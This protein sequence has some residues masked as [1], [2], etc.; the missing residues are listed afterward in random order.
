MASEEK[1][2]LVARDNSLMYDVRERMRHVDEIPISGMSGL[3]SSSK[4]ATPTEDSADLRSNPTTGESAL[5]QDGERVLEPRL[6][7]KRE[8][9]ISYRGLVLSTFLA[10]V[11]VGMTVLLSVQ[12]KFLY[13]IADELNSSCVD[14]TD[15]LSAVTLATINGATAVL[16]ST[17]VESITSEGTTVLLREPLVS[18][19]TLSNYFLSVNS[20]D[21]LTL[22]ENAQRFMRM[23]MQAPFFPYSDYLS[24]AYVSSVSASD[25]EY[26][27]VNVCQNALNDVNVT[28]F[29]LNPYYEASLDCIAT[30]GR[31]ALFD[32]QRC[33]GEFISFDA[34]AKRALTR[35]T[36]SRTA[37]SVR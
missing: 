21:R 11:V 8:V 24:Y 30:D 10:T 18:S 31:Y 33:A 15:A 3:D 25:D 6:T 27:D 4:N 35:L 34:L 5:Y 7:C 20:T 2:R 26:Y 32:L 17:Y 37:V 12:L 36:H 16:A 9:S 23:Q 19:G 14:G 22:L 29:Q 28:G 13:E 1:K